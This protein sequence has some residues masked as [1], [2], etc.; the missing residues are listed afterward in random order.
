[1]DK[2]DVV[3]CLICED[4]HYLHEEHEGICYSCWEKVFV[5]HDIKDFLWTLG[6]LRRCQ[7]CIRNPND[8]PKNGW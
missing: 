4:N 7:D 2:L 1:M 5:K 6:E 8:Y 3:K